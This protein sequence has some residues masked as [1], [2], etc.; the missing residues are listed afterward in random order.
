MQYDCFILDI[1]E[2]SDRII[3]VNRS[4]A[5][6]TLNCD[7]TVTRMLVLMSAGFVM[8][9]ERLKSDYRDD[10]PVVKRAKNALERLGGTQLS[11]AALRRERALFRNLHANQG[12]RIL[13]HRCKERGFGRDVVVAAVNG[14]CQT[15]DPTVGSILALLRHGLA[16]GNV[17][18]MSR[19]QAER[20]G[21]PD[22][23]T[24]TGNV[25]RDRSV[26][27]KVYFAFKWMEHDE[28]RPSA[29]PQH[30]RY[31]VAEFTI[32][33]LLDFWQD[34]RALVTSAAVQ[35]ALSPDCATTCC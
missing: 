8:V 35:P 12:W 2:R 23:T 27:D 22:P 13:E 33:A 29:E 9:Y 28:T 21:L 16:H 24:A 30:N 26:I 5:T 7:L 34:W 25:S 20:Y 1:L 6:K 14:G 15:T 19:A 18:P 3:G 17:W 31:R 4:V 32:E 10:D 11:V